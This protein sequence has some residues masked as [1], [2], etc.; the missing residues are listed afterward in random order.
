MNI[1]TD[2]TD[3]VS[4]KRF[5]LEVAEKVEKLEDTVAEQAERI[6]QLESKH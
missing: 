4:L 1:P 5:L 6:A 3:E 2:L